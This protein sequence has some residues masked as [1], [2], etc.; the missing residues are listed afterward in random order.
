MDNKERLRAYASKF[1]S[2]R[3][4]GSWEEL[5]EIIASGESSGTKETARFLLNIWNSD[6]RFNLS[7]AIARWDEPH[8][9]AF[10]W[11]IVDRWRHGAL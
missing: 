6:D 8:F 4:R 3:D 1:P 11:V 5:D 9:R 7:H 10:L 2:T